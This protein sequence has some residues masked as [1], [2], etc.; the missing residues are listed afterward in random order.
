MHEMEHVPTSGWDQPLGDGVPQTP[1]LYTGPDTSSQLAALRELEDMAAGQRPGYR[2]AAPPSPSV[3]PSPLSREPAPE[4]HRKTKE[5]GGILRILR[6][7]LKRLTSFSLIGG[8]VFFVSLI[9][10]I[11]LV[12]YCGL[13]PS[14]AYVVQGF[15]SIELSYLLNRYLT[16]RNQESGF[17]IA[18]WK[19]NI[20]KLLMTVVNMAA[21][22]LLVRFGMQYIVT[23][24]L[25][26]AIF[27]PINYFA[28]DLLVFVRPYHGKRRKGSHPDGLRDAPEFPAATPVRL[29]AVLPSVSVIIPCKSSEKTI[30][31]TVAALLEQDYPALKEVILVGD[32]NDSTFTAVRDIR[33]PRLILLEQEKIPGRRDPNVKRDKGIR[34][35]TALCAGP[36][37]RGL[38]AFGHRTDIDAPEASSMT[39]ITNPDGFAALRTTEPPRSVR[40]TTQFQTL[41]SLQD[42]A[43]LQGNR[44]GPPNAPSVRP[45]RPEEQRDISASRAKRLI[46]K[47]L[48]VPW[49]LFA[50]AAV[51]WP[52]FPI[53]ALQVVLASRLLW[54][55]TAYTDEALYLYSGSQEIN[56]WLH[57]FKV[58]DYQDYFSGSPAVYPPIG[59]IANAIGSL[60]GARLLSLGFVLSATALLY[61]TTKRLFDNRTAL[62]GTALFAALGV[63][64]FLSAFATYDPMALFLLALSAYLIIGRKHEYDTLTEVASSTILAA[65]AL[66]LAN[67]DKYATALWDPMVI[68]LAFCAPPIAGYSWRYGFGRACRFT[69][70]LSSFLVAGLAIGK[71]KY[72]QGILYTTVNRSPRQAGMGQPATLVFHDVW[73][74]AGVVLVIALLGA[75]LL[76]LP[77]RR[78]PL[79]AVGVLLILATVAAPLN[80]ARIGTSVSLHKHIVFGAWF[81]CILAGYALSRI[82][83]HRLLVGIGAA[84]LLLIVSALYTKQATGLFQA[85]PAENPAFIADLRPLVHPGSERYLIEGYSDI[86]AYYIGPSVN[87]IQWKEAVRYSYTDPQT[88]VTYLNGPAFRRAIE[89]RI[90]TLVILNFTEKNDYAVAADIAKYGGYQVIAHL[91]P[92]SIGSHNSYTVWRRIGR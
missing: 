29:P 31:A 21:Y 79:A 54:S 22:A 19:F 61:A 50:V 9:F 80:Q 58:Q 28:S 2:P 51:S 67:A 76:F 25:L 53:L 92:S 40:A 5:P 63:T 59:A 13:G 35:S 20:Q 34:E 37:T 56:H 68:G 15:F 41:S 83:R 7:H 77:G 52:L 16:W 72:I 1:A 88:G 39:S 78:S 81:G 85:W 55:N 91:P 42:I 86:P 10:Q 4:S 87:S 14:S 38:Q 6:K 70:A 71:S 3:R 47:V 48:G 32:V 73:E 30:R 27:T 64:Q 75:F 8:G 66:A 49:A 65:A 24:V 89:N 36:G 90:F 45:P 11:A 44:Y 60:T 69:A 43:E 46:R 33:D 74:W 12:R 57:G 23:N 17:W 82:L 18:L 62:L 26:T 84:S